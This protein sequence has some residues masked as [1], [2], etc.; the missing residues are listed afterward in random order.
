MGTSEQ[1]MPKCILWLQVTRALLLVLVVV[2]LETS[3][4]LLLVLLGPQ[5][6]LKPERLI[7]KHLLRRC[8]HIS[9][10][11]SLLAKMARYGK[12]LLVVN[13]FSKTIMFAD[14]RTNSWGTVQF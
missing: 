8:V 11:P 6:L 3:L 12:E 4:L 14:R 2:V 10:V 5:S 7:E 13:V 1:N 9:S